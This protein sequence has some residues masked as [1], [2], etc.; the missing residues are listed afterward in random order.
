MRIRFFPVVGG[1]I[2]LMIIASACG[3][4][5]PASGVG[6]SAGG[7]RT[8]FVESGRAWCW[9]QNQAGQLGDG[10]FED[11]DTPAPVVAADDI[12]SLAVGFA[13]TCAVKR[14]GE[15]AC[16]GSGVP[17]R[18]GSDPVTGCAA[19]AVGTSHACILTAS[20]A[21]KCW[22]TNGLGALGDGSTETRQEPVD[23]VG[24]GGGVA[25]LSAG[26]DF[27]CAVRGGAAKCWG[28]ND[29]GQL[30]VGTYAAGLTPQTVEG[31]DSGMTGIA[32]GMFHACAW[33]REGGIWCWGENL[34]GALGD[35]TNRNSPI[36]V[37]VRLT[38]GIQSVVAGAGHT[39][40][41]TVAGGVACWGDNARGQL[42]N[43]T[44]VASNTPVEAAGLTR[45]VVAIAAGAEHTCALLGGRTV[46]CWGSNN[47]GQL[48]NGTRSDSLVPADVA[49]P[50]AG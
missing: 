33:Y 7:N 41:L 12:L 45:G 3:G 1:S 15:V 30:G 37:V 21:V 26:T 34:L 8:C 36:P 46:K 22:G 32:A 9:G 16:W 23:V 25:S 6:I 17:D 4:W 10:T 28:S 13:Y 11:R 48:G 18:P 44:T 20:G 19:A 27:S 5:P 35:G 50:P 2:L 38:G 39:C 43:G 24:M 49:L 40:A 47:R 42:G 29:S 31:L 14:T